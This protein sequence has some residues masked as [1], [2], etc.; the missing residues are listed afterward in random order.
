METIASLST[1][2]SRYGGRG[3]RVYSESDESLSSGYGG[4]SQRDYRKSILS[5]AWVWRKSIE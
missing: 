2:A 4:Q 1:F 3:Q 5:M